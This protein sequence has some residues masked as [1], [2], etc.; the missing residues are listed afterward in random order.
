[1]NISILSVLLGLGGKCLLNWALVF[2]QRSHICR[3]FVGVFSVSLSVVDTAVTLIFAA[4]HIH[5]DG[6]LFLLDWQL[7]RYHTCLLVQIL[8]QVYSLLQWPVVL[9]AGL[10]HFCTVSLPAASSGVKGIIH[11]LVTV[12]LW[13]LTVLYVFLLSDFDPALEDVSLHQMN[14]CWVFHTTQILQV[15]TLLSLTLACSVLHA[16]CSSTLLENPPEKNQITNQSRTRP[17]RTIACQVLSIF[18]STWAPLLIFLAGLLLLPVGIP[19]YLGLNV[20]WLC[21]LNS[22]LITLVLC[23]AVPAPRLAQGLA[24]VPADSFCEWRIQFNLAAEDRT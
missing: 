24:A 17:R 15:V 5:T 6:L 8:G 16:V 20:A 1:M 23:V 12:L 3:S 2:L 13:S 21:F 7:T 4:I 10:D 14:Q 19:S 11:P 9:V 22:F 18:L